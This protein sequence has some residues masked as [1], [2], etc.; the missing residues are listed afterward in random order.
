MSSLPCLIGD[1]AS[2]KKK[3]WSIEVVE[4]KDKT[5]KIIVTHG[6]EGMKMTSSEKIISEG[7]NKGKKNET[8]AIQQAYLE[9]RAAW[10]KKKDS[11]YDLYEVSDKTKGEIKPC[12]GAGVSDESEKID[13]IISHIGHIES[14]AKEISVSAKSPMLALDYHKRG[15][16]IKFPCFVQR[17][18]DGTRCVGIPGIGLFSRNRKP[19]IHLNHI[20]E[21]V[22]SLVDELGT[23]QLDGELYADSKDLTFQQIV[24]L[25]KKEKLNS[26][27]VENQKKIYYNLYDL[28]N[29]EEYEKRKERLEKLF[30]KHKFKY[31]RLVETEECKTADEVRGFHD[32]YVDEGFEGLMLRN[33]KGKYK[34]G[35]RSADLQKFKMFDDD[36]FKV[37]GYS[38]GEGIEKGLVLWKCITKEKKEFD[39]RP[40]GSHEERS[41]LFKQASKYIGKDLTVRF[42]GLTD[43]GIPRFPVGI[44]FR[45]YE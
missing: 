4:L 16:S 22:N 29:E 19:Y 13:K 3:L 25:V 28:I 31:L 30:E 11:G 8:T 42:F 2:G 34:E 43:D 5:G 41:E 6:Y 35:L 44:G 12:G 38:E 23:I 17:K 18:Y 7:K 32:K 24:G 36:E 26:E 39:V 20:K 27:D 14:R 40:R 1:S 33:K 9:A 21:E 45:D 15:K 10:T 37:I